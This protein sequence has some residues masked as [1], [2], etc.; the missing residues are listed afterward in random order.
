MTPACSAA[1]D[2]AIVGAGISGVAC[3]SALVNARHSVAV[4][5][6]RPQV[7]GRLLSTS[8]GVDLGA[9]WAWP[10]QERKPVEWARKLG[11]STIPQRLDGNAFAFHQGRMQNVGNSGAMMAPCGGDAVRMQGGYAGLVKAASDAL[12]QGTLRLGCKVTKV[13]AVPADEAGG[14]AGLVRVTFGQ[15]A[16]NSSTG[17]STTSELIAKRVVLALPP[18]II[19]STIG[20][21]PALPAD[22]L[23]KQAGTLTWCGDWAKVA[24]SFRSPFWRSNGASG[25]VATPG[26]IQIWWEGG[27]GKDQGEEAYALTGL[28]VG[29]QT[30]ALQRL[31]ESEGSDGADP[32]RALVIE[33]LTPALGE[34]VTAEL[35]SVSA[36]AWITD[37]LTYNAGGNHRDYGHPLLS[38]VA[39]WGVHFAGTETEAANGHVEGAIRAG[40]RAA[41]E[42]MA[43]LAGGS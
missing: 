20:F 25:V 38:R 14:E 8:F 13:E 12:P 1:V 5:D 35:L 4:L 9:S 42:V 43:A 40:E 10:A 32:L 34:S 16:E 26:P 29:E 6:A 21:S 22:Q 37:E 7:G 24:A 15:A 3:A 2:V 31:S 27:G 11:V 39:P 33:A 23:R 17:V 30:R 41:E 18:G 19:A 36:K 28:G